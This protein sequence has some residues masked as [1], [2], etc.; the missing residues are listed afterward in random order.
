[1]KNEK[2]K[3]WI[4]AA[5]VLIAI[6]VGAFVL[7]QVLHKI[8]GLSIDSHEIGYLGMVIIYGI[9]GMFLLILKIFKVGKK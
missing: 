4:Q 2:Y 7:M 8:T 3:A 1:M 6:L 5:L 9:G